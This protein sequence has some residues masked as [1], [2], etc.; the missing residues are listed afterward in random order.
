MIILPTS[1]VARWLPLLHCHQTDLQLTLGSAGQRLIFS[2]DAV[3]LH[4]V[5]EQRHGDN[6]FQL[7]SARFSQHAAPYQR[8]VCTV[9]RPPVAD[10]VNVTCDED[11]TQALSD[12]WR[13]VA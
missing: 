2:C 7:S 3:R 9:L 11:V 1:G 4:E 5:R 8:D 12:G 6:R 10:A 13:F